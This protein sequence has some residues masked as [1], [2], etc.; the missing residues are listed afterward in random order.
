MRVVVSALYWPDFDCTPD[1]RRI[2][3]TSTVHAHH[4]DE[5][6]ACLAFL[7]LASE[8]SVLHERGERY[9]CVR[10]PGGLVRGVIL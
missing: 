5:L 7:R 10:G 6:S 2:A 4:D 8:Y 9:H 3:H 1:S